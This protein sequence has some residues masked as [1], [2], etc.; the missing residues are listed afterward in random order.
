MKTSDLE[1]VSEYCQGECGHIYKFRQKNHQM[2]YKCGKKVPVP[3]ECKAFTNSTLCGTCTS[4]MFD[5]DGTIKV[6]YK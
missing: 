1:V 6:D 5:V 4:K 3:L 2:C